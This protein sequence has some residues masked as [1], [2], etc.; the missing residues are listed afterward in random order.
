MGKMIFIGKYDGVVR[1]K[2]SN[3]GTTVNHQGTSL[4]VPGRQEI[5]ADVTVKQGTELYNE[6]AE[7]FYQDKFDMICDFGLFKGCYIVKSD[8]EFLEGEVMTTFELVI[9]HYN[10]DDSV[11]TLLDRKRKLERM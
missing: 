4:Q 6:M 2:F 9:D 11:F 7:H 1:P 5:T 8:T 3:T 10:N